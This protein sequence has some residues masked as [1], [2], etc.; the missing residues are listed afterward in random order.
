MSGSAWPERAGQYWNDD[1]LN[2]DP[3]V[4]LD[5]RHDELDA[6]WSK[7]GK[8]GTEPRYPDKEDD[9]RERCAYGRSPCAPMPLELA[10]VML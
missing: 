3:S 9:G 4:E 2:D 8:K 1:L 5:Q 7:S 6:A 10:G